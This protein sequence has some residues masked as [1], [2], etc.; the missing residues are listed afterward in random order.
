M[1]L[2]IFIYSLGGG[3]AERV[4][5]NLANYWAKRGWEITIVTL[6]GIEN[7]SYE[8]DASISRISLAEFNNEFGLISRVARHFWRVRAL[9]RVL[10]ETKPEVALAMMSTANVL[11]ALA[12]RGLPGVCAIGSER[13]F[14][15]R[16]PLGRMWEFLRRFTYGYLDAVVALTEECAHWIGAN[17]SARLT[18][19]IPNPAP[20]P[21]PAHGSRI[22]PSEI[23]SPE[24]KILLAVGRLSKEKNFDVLIDV[25]TGLAKQHLD[26]DLVILGE[27][28][29][30]EALEAKVSANN[31]VAQIFLPG[32]AGNVGDWY[33]EADLYVMTS[34]FEGFPNSLAE[35]LA[36]GV[37][38]IS[39]DCDT[40]PRDIIRHGIDGL[41]VPAGDTVALMSVLSDL[42]GDD[43]LRKKFSQRA[44]DARERF[45]MAR[46]TK[47]WEELFR[48]VIV[49][50]RF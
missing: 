44:V 39:F 7:D 3:G 27:G 32:R 4:T 19:V 22:G 12:T 14:P 25:F 47:V 37:P 41:L 30:R 49:R 16:L 1:R 42:M 10:Q 23:S 13:T 17:S 34:D 40:G 24:R 29:A 9:R 46:V 8:L 48:Q 36:H 5:V 38:A 33:N 6:A 21:L 50:K 15:P 2:L 43:E 35:S 28:P 45:S 18:P 26:W 11:L 20:W 31:M